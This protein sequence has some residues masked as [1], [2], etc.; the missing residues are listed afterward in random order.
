MG[1]VK[2]LSDVSF[3]AIT[4][5][6]TNAQVL[7]LSA[8]ENGG[9][10][11][12]AG[13]EF[14]NNAVSVGAQGAERRITHVADGVNPTDAANVRQ[15]A[16]LTSQFDPQVVELQNQMADVVS[17]IEALTTRLDDLQ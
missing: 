13:S 1:V 15:L 8:S 4:E 10:A 2:S 6:E 9:V 11:L 3:F 12:G 14:V 7:K 17:R 5:S 16:Q